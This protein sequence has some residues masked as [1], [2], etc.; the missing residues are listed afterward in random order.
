MRGRGMMRLESGAEVQSSAGVRRE[1]GM[2]EG[3]KAA[4]LRLK[5]GAERHVDANARVEAD[6]V[7]HRLFAAAEGGE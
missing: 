6:R 3:C 7:L 1:G 4:H 2:R 5:G